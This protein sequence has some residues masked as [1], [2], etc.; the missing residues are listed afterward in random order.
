M[1]WRRAQPV[2]LVGLMEI[3]HARRVTDPHAPASLAA[4]RAR[5]GPRYRW[6][7]LLTVMMGTMASVMASTIV[8]VAVPDM[9]LHF[10]LGQE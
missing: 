8:N 3:P 1:P 6:Y 10:A 4:L 9:S 5:F 7:V 2:L